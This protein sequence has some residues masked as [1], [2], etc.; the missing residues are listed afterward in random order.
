MLVDDHG[1]ITLFDFDECAY[2]WFA[3]DIAIALFYAAVDEDDSAAFTRE[4][5][6]HFLRGYRQVAA[7]D[8]Q[9]LQELPAFLRLREIELYAVMHRDF[10]VRN[11]D[12]PWCSRFMHQRKYRIEHDVPF[13]DFDLTAFAQASQ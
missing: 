6:S 13:V 9:W 3:N 4:F 2:S 10:D 5:M 1:N 8:A 7:L 12:A 11:I